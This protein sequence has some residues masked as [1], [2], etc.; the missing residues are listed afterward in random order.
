LLWLLIFSNEGTAYGASRET[1]IAWIAD[2]INVSDPNAG[3]VWVYLNHNTIGEA[4]VMAVD[5]PAEYGNFTGAVLNLITKCGKDEYHGKFEFDFQGKPRG[6]WRTTNHD[7]YFDDFPGLT[8]P[9]TQCVDI[10]AQVGGPLT[11]DK[12]WFYTGLQW[13]KD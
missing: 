9:V 13:M 1:G 3:A 8:A 4:K 11:R 7:A 10:N 5:L 6:F 2:G 12:L